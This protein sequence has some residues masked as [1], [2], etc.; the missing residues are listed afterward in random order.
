M[1]LGFLI[2]RFSIKG[3]ALGA[4]TGTLLAGVLVGQMKIDIPDLVKTVAFIAFLFALGYKVGP[5]FFAGLR[6]GGLPQVV[7]AVVGCVVGLGVAYAMAKI[8]GYDA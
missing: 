5:Q 8:M 6:K 3:V 1:A 7:V 4:V 2:G